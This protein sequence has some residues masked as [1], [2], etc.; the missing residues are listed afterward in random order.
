VLEQEIA[1]LARAATAEH[2]VIQAGEPGLEG[3]VFEVGVDAVAVE[4]D[5]VIRAASVPGVGELGLE[6][7][8]GRGA[9]GRDVEARAHV[10]GVEALQQAVGDGTQPDVGR[11][12]RATDDVEEAHAAVGGGGDGDEVDVGVALDA[13]ERADAQGDH[14]A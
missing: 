1:V 3:R 8:E 10:L 12:A 6:A 5:D 9:Q 14:G 2:E 13:D 4:V 11:T 7:L